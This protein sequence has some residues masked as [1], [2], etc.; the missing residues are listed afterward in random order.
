MTWG[1]CLALPTPGHLFPPD[2]PPLFRLPS[3]PL[4]PPASM[5]PWWPH[6]HP[7]GPQ[8]WHQSSS[9][10][11]CR[12]PVAE[13]VLEPVQEPGQQESPPSLQLIKGGYC[14]GDWEPRC[15]SGQLPS[16]LAGLFKGPLGSSS[17]DM[18][19]ADCGPS[20]TRPHLGKLPRG[21]PATLS[22]SSSS[23][24]PWWTSLGSH[25]FPSSS[26]D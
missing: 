19:P 25:L 1:I 2:Q 9:W 13:C 4:G 6:E 3:L 22:P 12:W 26:E 17:Q 11:G 7:P 23:V 5:K 20:D 24:L 15:A 8:A 16:C 10:H 18:L 14:N 21:D